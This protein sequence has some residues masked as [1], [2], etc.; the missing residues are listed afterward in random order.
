MNAHVQ[1][2]DFRLLGFFGVSMDACQ[3]LR[4]TR[5]HRQDLHP[6]VYSIGV[7]SST[8]LELLSHGIR[9]GFPSVC[10]EHEGWYNNFVEKMAGGYNLFCEVS[11]LAVIAPDHDLEES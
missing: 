10:G 5:P 1:T 8:A 3:G 6:L 9:A 2:V 11:A 7:R 4:Y